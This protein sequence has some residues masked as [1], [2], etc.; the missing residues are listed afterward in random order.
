MR[1]STFEGAFG[2]CEEYQEGQ[3]LGDIQETMLYG[4]FDENHRAFANG[5]LLPAGRERRFP[6]DDEIDLIFAV[7]LLLVSL[8]GFETIEASMVRDEARKNSCQ[9]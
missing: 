2:R 4:A 9:R 5:L 7:R 1:F 6:A 8:P 3:V